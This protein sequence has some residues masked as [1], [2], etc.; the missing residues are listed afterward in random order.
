M[1]VAVVIDI[2]SGRRRRLTGRFS[3][4]GFVRLLR[5]KL[6]GKLVLIC[7]GGV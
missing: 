4:V 5:G 1:T 2:S 3:L 7:G 6:A